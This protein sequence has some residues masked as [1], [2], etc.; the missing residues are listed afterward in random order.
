MT[1]TLGHDT[2][3]LQQ[4]CKESSPQQSG[5]V[6]KPGAY[7]GVLLKLLIICYLRVQRGY[8]EL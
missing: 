2:Q 7:L 5:A 6:L 8:L 4:E 1:K 3:L